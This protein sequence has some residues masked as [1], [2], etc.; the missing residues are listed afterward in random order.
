V[1]IALYHLIISSSC[2]FVQSAM[3]PWRSGFSQQ[4][5]GDPAVGQTRLQ[6][7]GGHRP[8]DFVKRV[9]KVAPFA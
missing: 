2:R 6:Q 3:L 1:T 7:Q 9:E 8:T 5:L 4:K